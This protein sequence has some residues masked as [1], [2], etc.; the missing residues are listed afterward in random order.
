MHVDEEPALLVEPSSKSLPLCV[1]NLS[2]GS[3]IRAGSN[4]IIKYHKDRRESTCTPSLFCAPAIST[5]QVRMRTK[6]LIVI[7]VTIT[8]VI[9]TLEI[10]QLPGN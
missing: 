10:Y 2:M 1:G 6:Y 7:A 8:T 3:R 4:F 5:L 9:N